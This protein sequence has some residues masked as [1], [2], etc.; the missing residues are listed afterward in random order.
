MP[1]RKEETIMP[2][3]AAV[4]NYVGH[5]FSDAAPGHRFN[6]YFPIWRTDWSVDKSGKTQAIRAVTALPDTVKK[7]LP[8]LR[9][10]QQKTLAAHPHSFSLPAK[11]TAPFATGLGNEHPVENGFAFL[12]PYGLP[13]LAGSGVKGVLRRAAEEL[14]LFDPPLPPGEGRGEGDSN[15]TML[16]VWWLFGFEGA[17][18]AWWPLSR[19]EEREFSQEQ[20]LARADWKARF[21]DHLATLA[22]RPDWLEFIER[23]LPKGPAKARYLSDP[24]LFVNALD[25]LRQEIHLR[26][27]LDVWDVFPQPPSQG[28]HKDKLA[29]EI[30][31]PHYSDYY[32]GK[33]SAAY[34]NGATPHDAGQPNPIP[35]LAVP[36]GSSFDF[37]VVCQ[38]NRLPEHLRE[39][40]KEHL[41]AIFEHAFDWLGF[42][43]KTAVGYGAMASKDPPQKT[44]SQ[45]SSEVVWENATVAYSVS[46]RDMTA[47]HEGNKAVKREAKSFFDELGSKGRQERAKSG[48]LKA[49]VKVRITQGQ[50]PELL[51]ILPPQLA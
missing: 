13:Y 41:Q 46:T 9:D 18:G 35:F 22:N 50:P 7:L 16:D 33:T 44:Q 49:R 5:D 42:G 17:A 28:P 19:K 20:K 48:Q 1:C 39:N 51:E 32:Q 29:V 45:P 14:A 21:D 3:V 4:P 15:L 6:L 26:G 30:M 25:R 37:H 12:T 11:S 23:V 40:W 8:A 34:P 47:T 27:A 43:A 10:R 38:P 2:N 36:A 31:T 24:A